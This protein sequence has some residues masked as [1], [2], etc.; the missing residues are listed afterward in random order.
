MKHNCLF[1]FELNVVFFN[2]TY[3]SSDL[4]C[5]ADKDVGGKYAHANCLNKSIQTKTGKLLRMDS[6][7]NAK[8][9]INLSKG[10]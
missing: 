7:E 5:C 10:K 1:S 8:A 6:K 9:D 4:K 3:F 2:E